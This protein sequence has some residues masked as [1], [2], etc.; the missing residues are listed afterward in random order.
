MLGLEWWQIPEVPPGDPGHSPTPAELVYSMACT[1]FLLRSCLEAWQQP[2]DG[3]LD[4]CW[5]RVG[6]AGAG[7]GRGGAGG[8]GATA[9]ESR[10]E[11]GGGGAG[12]G[13]AAGGGA[14]AGG[15]EG[16]GAAGG[17]GAGGGA[18][19]GAGVGGAGAAAAAG[20]AA[21]GVGTGTS[22]AAAVMRVRHGV[23]GGV[24][25][26]TTNTAGSM[27]TAFEGCAS[28]LAAAPR[29]STSSGPGGG[30]AATPAGDA[31]RKLPK[32]LHNLPDEYLPAAVQKQLQYISTTWPAKE[33][34][35]T[36][37]AGKVS[38]K[39]F[40]AMKVPA[41]RELLGALLQLCDV[42]LQEVP[43]PLGCNNPAC[44][45][46]AGES[47]FSIAVGKR[48]TRCKMAFYCSRECQKVDWRV[49]KTLCSRMAEQPKP[50]QE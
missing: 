7:G 48:C 25:Q 20:A 5:G 38:G 14:G 3:A 40:M 4:G 34:K 45:N 28:P 41:Q 22:A 27:N 43:V 44:S 36:S 37:A 31:S 49:H 2:Y 47:E 1:A 30:A 39:Y 50:Q 33:L 23:T 16:G 42:L 32:R 15:R 10:G 24:S 8:V 18:A 17:A 19:E 11:A 26:S 46:L 29:S 13:G 21:G 12:A 6:G 35:G 9:G